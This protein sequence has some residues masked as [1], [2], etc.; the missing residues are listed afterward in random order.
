MLVEA[1]FVEGWERDGVR[2]SLVEAVT[3]A[4]VTRW[5][6]MG[7]RGSLCVDVWCVKGTAVGVRLLDVV[8]RCVREELVLIVSGG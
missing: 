2:K 7:R 3:W 5:W 8:L 6:Q 1:F 4:A